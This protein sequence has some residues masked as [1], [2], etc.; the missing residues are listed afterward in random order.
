MLSH[1]LNKKI[2]IEKGTSSNTSVSSPTLSYAEYYSTMANVY[3]RSGD[4]RM[5]E[6]EDLMFTTE[7]TIRYNSLTKV[8]TNKYRIKYDDKYYRI[9]EIIEVEPKQTLKFITTRFYEE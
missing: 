5:N 8:I 1:L 3:V 4:A 2:I 9:I 7:F 6:N